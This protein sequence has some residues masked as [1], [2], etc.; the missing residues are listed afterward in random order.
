MESP[1]Y[2]NQGKE[3]Q[4]Y[5]NIL[6]RRKWMLLLLS[7]SAGIFGFFLTYMT[8]K[9]Y[10]AE[11]LILV[12]PQKA[13]QF[14]SSSNKEVLNVPIGQNP[15]VETPGKTYIELITSDTVIS[16]VVRLLNLDK[17]KETDPTITFLGIPK[18]EIKAKLKEIIQILKYGQTFEV[19][20]FLKTVKA[21]QKG[22]SLATTI[23][24]YVFSISFKSDDPELAAKVPNTTAETF[25]EYILELNHMDFKRVRTYMESKLK[26]SQLAIIKAGRE[27]QEFK[28]KHS[29]FN[30]SE[31]YKEK[32]KIISDLEILAEKNEVEL[33]GLLKI[34]PPTNPEV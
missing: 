4:Y 34:F 2:I 29:T 6:W 8:S 22:L 31:D 24:T 19:N 17:E 13:V 7:L 28:E 10:E 32:L 3:L 12:R 25:L 11:T 21:V 30:I 15:S 16:K 33:A 23:D 14:S 20:Q 5:F 18:T 1:Q 9:K 26:E 27:L